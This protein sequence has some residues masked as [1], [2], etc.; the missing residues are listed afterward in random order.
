MKHTPGPWVLNELYGEI[1]QGHEAGAQICTFVDAETRD[2]QT[3]YNAFLVAAAPELLEALK[4][5]IDCRMVPVSSASD[6]GVCKH[7]KQVIV[8]DM[9]RAAIA[10]AENFPERVDDRE[11]QSTDIR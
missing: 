11:P 1:R 2:D 4:A 9:I 10:K 6:G 3:K 8:A 7:F 5:A